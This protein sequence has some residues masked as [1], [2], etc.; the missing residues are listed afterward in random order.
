MRSFTW[1]GKVQRL[2]AAI[3]CE[4]MRCCNS[5]FA[6]LN[7]DEQGTAWSPAV[8]DNSLRARVY[9]WFLTSKTAQLASMVCHENDAYGER[10]TSRV[11]QSTLANCESIIAWLATLG[12]RTWLQ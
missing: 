8:I 10:A 11:E 7:G 4:L 12:D 5:S 1:N 3:S 6:A 9:R 2:T